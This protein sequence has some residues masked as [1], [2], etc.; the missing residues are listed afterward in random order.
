MY[1]EKLIN[2]LNQTIHFW[3]KRTQ[4]ISRDHGNSRVSED[5]KLK[6]S[7]TDK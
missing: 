2:A 4:W 5:Y 3:N 1:T 7:W 6:Q